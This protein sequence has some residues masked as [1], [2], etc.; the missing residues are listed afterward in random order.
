M[1]S[2]C[3][4]SR[5]SKSLAS[6]GAGGPASVISSQAPS[7]TAFSF[8]SDFNGKKAKI[9]Q[10]IRQIDDQKMGIVKSAVFQNLLSCLDVE[11]SR[12]DMDQC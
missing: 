8:K 1:K 11:I 9:L 4:A 10:T 12:A 2:R 3:E 5:R 7:S 6:G